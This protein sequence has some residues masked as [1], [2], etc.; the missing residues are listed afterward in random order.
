[1]YDFWDGP[2]VGHRLHV[3]ENRLR[4]RGVITKVEYDGHGVITFTTEFGR[5]HSFH[6]AFPYGI[7]GLRNG[8]LKLL[9]DHRRWAYVKALPDTTD[10]ECEQNAHQ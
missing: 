1:M 10:K 2:F 8:D 3:F 7:K 5:T 6:H 4:D 9:G